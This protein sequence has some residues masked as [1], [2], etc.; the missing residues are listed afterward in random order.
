[1]CYVRIRGSTNECAHHPAQDECQS[2]YFSEVAFAQ[3]L[4]EQASAFFAEHLYEMSNELYKVC[5]L[6]TSTFYFCQVYLR[7]CM[8][9]NTQR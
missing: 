4:E 9:M 1:M 7:A 8:C 3:L 2:K 6:S 5:V